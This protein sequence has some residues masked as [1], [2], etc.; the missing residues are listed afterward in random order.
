MSIQDPSVE[1]VLMARHADLPGGLH[2]RRAIPQARRR[3][4]GPFI[5][6]DQMGP[7]LL[8][9]D[10]EIAVLAHPH[11][12]LSTVTFLFEGE[13]LHRDSLGTVQQIL[14]GEVNWMTAGRGIVHSERLRSAS[15][16]RIF[17]VQIRVALPQRLEECAPTFEHYGT[18]AVPTVSERGVDVRVIAGS[19]FGATSQ[20]RTSSTLFYAECR[21][22]AGAVLQLGPEYEE[23]A[24]FL[25]EGTLALAQAKLKTGQTAFFRRGSEILLRAEE[26]SRVLLLGGEPLDGPRY[27]S[28]NFVSSSKERLQQ[29]TEA[30]QKQR[31]PRIPDETSYIP[32]PQDG[33]APVNY[34]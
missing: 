1:L 14:P 4:V 32:L 22:Q 5:F 11:I 29:A 2:V 13:A 9:A 31:F 23:R 28:W 25:I 18:D 16:G 12:G 8:E 6:L 19:L 7:A 15:E 33:S 10:R 27:I 34:P 3:M 21:L 30:W 26:P 24:A 17:G 20:V